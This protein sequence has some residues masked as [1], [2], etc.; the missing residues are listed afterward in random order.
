MKKIKIV[1]FFLI[2][3]ILLV[4][5]LAFFNFS[6]SEKI[7]VEDKKT[8]INASMV[9]EN[10][11]HEIYSNGEKFARISYKEAVQKKD[12][13]RLSDI[14]V[15]IFKNNGE[16]SSK[17]AEF[18]DNILEF[19]EEIKGFLPEKEIKVII[20]PPAF[21]KDKILR[22]EKKILLSF[23]KFSLSGEN[24][25][26]KIEESSL[27][28]ASK[29]KLLS[30]D[31]Q[32]NSVF[33]VSKFKKDGVFMFI[34]DTSII[35]NE[36]K[37]KSDIAVYLEQ[38]QKILLRG[39]CLAGKREAKIYFSEG[40]IIREEEENY[41]L[42]IPARFFFKTS[43]LKGE[44]FNLTF[45]SKGFNAGYLK[46]EVN[47]F[48]L[49]GINNSYENATLLLKGLNPYLVS[50]FPK[51]TITGKKY[52]LKDKVLKIFSPLYRD[53]DT[54]LVSSYCELKENSVA[55]FPDK[56]FGIFQSYSFKASSAYIGK[57]KKV[58]K[59]GEIN[60][61][62]NSNDKLKGETIEFFP[63]KTVKIKGSA[64]V[65]R[66][67]KRGNTTTVFSDTITVKDNGNKM[68]LYGKIK[69]FGGNFKAFPKSAIVFKRY[70]VLFNCNFEMEGK[71]TGFARVM[72]VNFSGRYSY[73]FFA[74][75]KGTDGS[76][77]KGD[78]LTLDNLTD[79]I[80]IEKTQEKGQA[81]VK[82]KL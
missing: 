37:I 9:I 4:V 66:E 60:S 6:P 77:L 23:P 30:K 79:R 41:A 70:A 57:E 20:S 80:F 25:A 40:E 3:L 21:L 81:E 19:Q 64:F 39:N 74:T 82:I 17:H 26:F 36:I 76:T 51:R 53:K 48:I 59:N 47:G 31:F 62:D 1:R 32:I 29:S 55:V 12:V 22:G 46:S 2:F 78:K 69:I 14:N 73:L 54:L 49:S 18:K 33:N 24:F 52:E 43:N 7:V 5:L 15:K 44:G 71:Y 8:D 27:Y 28:L 11:I 10:G 38:K 61:L 35:T 72:V 42:K 50:L 58:V 13:L 63:D 75:V 45:N 67:M 16:L 56:V 68:E 34:K 65:S